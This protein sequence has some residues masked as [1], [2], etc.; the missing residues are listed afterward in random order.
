MKEFSN[1]LHHAF[2]SVSY[3]HILASMERLLG[4]QQPQEELRVLVMPV[5]RCDRGGLSFHDLDV[6]S[7]WKTSKQQPSTRTGNA[8]D[9]LK[10]KRTIV[11]LA[12][13]KNLWELWDSTR[14]DRV[15]GGSCH[16][17]L[18]SLA[19]KASRRGVSCWGIAW[20]TEAW[21]E[22]VTFN[23]SRLPSCVV[24]GTSKALFVKKCQFGR[25]ILPFF[26]CGPS[27]SMEA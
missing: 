5:V 12:K 15:T 17:N 2:S 11:F 25:P 16:R 6:T 21:L 23:S 9:Q 14:P 24:M 26:M 27:S 8:P 18:P 3:G 20:N 22:F 7:F 13:I 19:G 1:K 4:M 10:A